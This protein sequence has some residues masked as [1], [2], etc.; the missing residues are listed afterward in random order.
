MI[1]KIKPLLINI[2]IPL[3]VGG[4]GGF[5]SSGSMDAFKMMNKPPL[6]PP[7]WLFPVVWTIL[8]IMMGV[9]A[10]LVRDTYAKRDNA[11]RLYV[12]QLI[13]N[14]FWTLIFFNL[15]AYLFALIWLLVLWGLILATFI[16]FKNIRPAAGYL[17]IPYLC[18]VTFAA[19]L[20]LGV[21]IM[22]K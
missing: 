21:F 22:N 2:C 17:L 19:Y 6:S 4:L 18:W 13:F 8:Y 3:V 16:S 14:F 11:M 7:G 9:A 5:I 12:V 15:G 10:Y 20:N 1:I